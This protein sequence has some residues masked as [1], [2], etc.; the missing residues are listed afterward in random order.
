ME[1]QY[2]DAIYEITPLSEKD[3]FYIIERYKS[4]FTFPLHSHAEYEF[5]FVENGRGI[6]RIVG[7][8]IEEIR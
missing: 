5:N 4:E 1:K 7:D 3:C 2:E 6:Q 8:S